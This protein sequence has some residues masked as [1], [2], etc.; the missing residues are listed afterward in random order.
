MS[1]ESVKVNKTPAKHQNG[2]NNLIDINLRITKGKAM[3]LVD[4]LRSG[5]QT[6]LTEELG[7]WILLE[8]QRGTDGKSII[9]D[10]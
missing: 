1:Q 5:N 6:V 7:H 2:F 9:F 3:A 4:A 8:S 10:A